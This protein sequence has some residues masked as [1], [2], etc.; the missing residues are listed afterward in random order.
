M[1]TN[2]KKLAQSLHMLYCLNNQQRE[3]KV[4][5]GVN[6]VLSSYQ[7]SLGRAMDVTANNIANVNTTG[8]KRQ[9][10][11]FDT[12]LARPEPKSVFHFAIDSGTYRDVAQG[13]TAM[14]GNPLDVA[15]QGKGYVPI[16]TEQG[17]LYTRAGSFQLNLEGELVTAA[18]DKV[19]GDGNQTITFPADAQ[20]ILIAP[21]GTITAKS[22]AGSGVTQVG[23]L[24]VVTFADEQALSPVGDSLYTTEQVPEPAIGSRVVQGAVE[25]SNV[26]AVKEMTRMIE[27]SRAYQRVARLLENENERI[28]RAIQRLGKASA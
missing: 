17:L 24:G 26:P 8:Y 1:I 16:Q 28:G 15:V 19:L 10:V 25:Q 13:S 11:A 14:T 6:L 9:D 12:Y 27:I 7:D 22:G 4:M 23:K 21:D 2:D 18:G 5:Q 3:T 20:D